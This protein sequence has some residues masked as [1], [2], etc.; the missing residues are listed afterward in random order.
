MLAFHPRC[1]TRPIDDSGLNIDLICVGSTFSLS[2]SRQ[3]PDV[4]SCRGDERRPLSSSQIN[5]EMALCATGTQGS[6]KYFHMSGFFVLVNQL[7]MGIFGPYGQKW[8]ADRNMGGGDGN[9]T[10][11]AQLELPLH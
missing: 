1:H 11:Y 8:D 4:S 9:V 3:L 10:Q 5:F 7:E 2:F 6:W